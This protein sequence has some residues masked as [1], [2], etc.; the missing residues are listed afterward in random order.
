ML[1]NFEEYD[2]DDFDQASF[3]PL[4]P[5][6]Y[7]V[8]VMVFNP[9]EDEHSSQ[10]ISRPPL[11]RSRP[12]INFSGR[13]PAVGPNYFSGS[14]VSRHPSSH[15]SGSTLHSSLN[16]STAHLFSRKTFPPTDSSP[17]LLPEVITSLTEVQLHHNPHYH[18][19]LQKYDQVCEILIGRDLVESRAAQ[20]DIAGSNIYQGM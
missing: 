12:Q 19:L 17:V 14:T 18:K 6:V 7:A 11:L 3:G 5:K 8:Q 4:S 13:H 10:Y 1:S 15:M 9:D 2:D 16:P 20:R